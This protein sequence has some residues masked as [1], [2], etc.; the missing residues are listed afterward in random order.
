MLATVISYLWH[1]F[2][3]LAVVNCFMN[4]LFYVFVPAD[5]RAALIDNTGAPEEVKAVWKDR[6]PPHAQTVVCIILMITLL[7]IF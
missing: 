2:V 5:V 1:A 7:T 3:L 6:K 4:W